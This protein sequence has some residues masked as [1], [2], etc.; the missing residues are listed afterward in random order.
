MQNPT[1]FVL[2]SGPQCP[3][4][5]QRSLRS[6]TSIFL[7]PFFVYLLLSL[8]NEAAGRN[9][10]CSW[11]HYWWC[12]SACTPALE[13]LQSTPCKNRQSHFAETSLYTVNS[14][15]SKLTAIR[16]HE[17][18]CYCNDS[19]MIFHW[20]SEQ[21]CPFDR[22]TTSVTISGCLIHLFTFKFPKDIELCAGKH[23]HLLQLV[24]IF[25]LPFLLFF[26]FCSSSG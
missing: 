14:A 3:L 21:C 15:S 11:D 1:H 4:E 12:G 24:S 22:L 19:G 20:P 23:W 2:F 16:A 10:C 9:V 6:C 5:L 25:Q 13:E 26:L 7:F 18:V 17:V 8:G